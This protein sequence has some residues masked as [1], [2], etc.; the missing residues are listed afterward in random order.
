MAITAT[1]ITRGLPNTPEAP[2]KACNNVAAIIVVFRTDPFL[3][4]TP[5]LA[6]LEKKTARRVQPA[7][8]E[9]LGDRRILCSWY[10]AGRPPG[11]A[12]AANKKARALIES[13]AQAG[14][15]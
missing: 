6:S 11:Q 15:T 8:L 14:P 7:C 2:P 9:P 12:G 13:S 1:I 4:S 10:R 3:C 5:F